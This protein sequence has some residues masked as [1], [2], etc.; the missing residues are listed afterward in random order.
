MKKIVITSTFVILSSITLF[1]NEGIKI[2][3]GSAS[4]VDIDVRIEKNF[5]YMDELIESMNQTIEHIDKTTREINDL[6]KN[7]A[8]IVKCFAL[9]DLK[10]DLI[11]LQKRLKE[12]SSKEREEN[13]NKLQS[14]YDEEKSNAPYCK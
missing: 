7:H 10:G 6:N 11:D 12:T 2:D 9:D 1:A 14:I 3:E 5:K 8:K 13:L 4:K